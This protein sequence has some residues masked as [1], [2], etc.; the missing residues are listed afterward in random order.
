MQLA[1]NI[2]AFVS[3]TANEP[4]ILKSTNS[5]E[6]DKELWFAGADSLNAGLSYETRQGLYAGILMHS[7]GAYPINN[8]NTESLSGYTTFDWKMRV[9]L[10]DTL[11]LTGS[12]DN[13]FNQRYQ[14]SPGFPDGGRVFQVGLSST[15]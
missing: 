4:R 9:T 14:L 7:L 15:F 12:V 5:A 1:K 2:Y 6:V 8:T 10:S 13:I 3:Y 11:V